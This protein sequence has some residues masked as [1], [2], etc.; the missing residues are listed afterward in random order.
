MLQLVFLLSVLLN[1]PPSL[2]Y[3]LKNCTVDSADVS[4]ACNDRD[5]TAIPH[6]IPKNASSLDLNSNRIPQ[7]NRTDLSGLSKLV[8]FQMQLNSLLQIDDGAFSDLAE[9]TYLVVSYNLLTNLSDDVFQGLSKLACLSLTHN[10]ISCISPLAFRPLVSLQIVELSDNDLHR[11]ADIVPILCLLTLRELEVGMNRFPSFDSDDLPLNT[12]NLRRLVFNLNPLT[13]FSVTRDVFPH[14]QVMDLSKCSRGFEWDVPDKTF[15]RS[16][17]SLYLSG[18][19]VSF[20]TYRTMLRS[21]ESLQYLWLSYV[22]EWFD[23]GLVDVACQ[24]PSLTNLDLTFNNIYIL[25]DTLL[26]NCSGLTDLALLGNEMTDLSENSLKP[27]NRLKQLNLGANFLTRVPL[28]IRGLSSLVALEMFSNDIGDLGCSDFLNLTS[29]TQLFLSKNRISKLRGCVFRDL[30]NLRLL[31]VDRNPIIR[32]YDTFKVGLR[33]LGIL[34]M[35]GNN[36]KQLDKGDFSSLSSL[37]SLDLKSLSSCRVN[38]GT[39]EGLDRLEILTLYSYSLGEYMFRG[40]SHLKTLTVYLPTFMT[41]LTHGIH[42]GPPFLQ[43]P[44]LTELR[45]INNN[46]YDLVIPPDVLGGLKYL[47]LFAA[48]KFFS[49]TPHPDTFTHTPLL[50]SLQII[51]SNVSSPKPELFRPIPNLQA[52]DLSQNKLRSLDFLAR[53]DLPALSWL[54]VKE[55]ELTVINEMVLRS[56]TAL[57]YLNLDNNPFTC[58][59]SNAGFIQWVKS[60]NRTQVVNAHQYTCSFPPSKQG[61]RLLDF[62]IQ[63]CWADVDFLC[64]V[65]SCCLVVLTLLTSFL[66][67]FLRWQLVYAV[68]LF[69]AFVHDRRRRKEG[70]PHRYDAFVSYNVHDEDW[71]YREMLPVLEGEQGWRLCLHHRDFQPGKPIIENITDAIYGSRKTICVISHR[72]LQSEWC[73]REIQMASFRLFDEQ[74]DVLVLLFLEDIPSHQLSPYYRMRKLVKRRTYLS[75]P[76][77]VQHPGVFWQNVRRA[78]ETGDEDAEDTDLLTASVS[79]VC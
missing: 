6:D 62:D 8:Y 51:G 73:S 53:V 74:K 27:L 50:T 29:L 55:N 72:Y 3:A 1:V 66:Y 17:T 54:K 46:R 63:S 34:K 25:N 20:E 22:K 16:L 60:N 5:L 65:S 36:L 76:Q 70:A 61:S 71:V 42:D 43:L 44:S 68:H 78:L 23:N 14:L 52:L 31:D 12:S 57:T 7:I 15:L 2:P 4:V 10:R 26:R 30:K 69:L 35:N 79:P 47:H 67:H 58:D 9:L 40:L 19:E 75:W 28:A 41:S 33:N 24:I 13:R 21:T 48:E 39:F 56:L 49:E 38:N 45:I 37:F 32:L 11:L 77:A 18:I 59:C 64:F